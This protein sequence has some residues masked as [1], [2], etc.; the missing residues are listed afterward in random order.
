[1]VIFTES[2]CFCLCGFGNNEAIERKKR[3]L[4][5]AR[6][7]EVFRRDQETAELRRMLGESARTNM[8]LQQQ[9]DNR[10][11]AERVRANNE[12]FVQQMEGVNLEDD[13]RDEA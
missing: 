10:E 1:M 5:A 13:A 7:Q 6:Q 11:A 3:Q 12:I 8:A 2:H 9:L 4:E